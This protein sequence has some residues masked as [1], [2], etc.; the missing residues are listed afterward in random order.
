[1]SS[2]AFGPKATPAGLRSHRLVLA[3]AAVLSVPSMNEAPPVTR[4]MMLVTV[5]APEKVAESPVA[6]LKVPKLWKTLV[7]TLVPPEM[8]TAPVGALTDVPSPLPTICASAIPAKRANPRAKCLIGRQSSTA[9]PLEARQYSPMTNPCTCREA[10]PSDLPAVLA[11]YAQPELD[12][13]QVL[14]LGEAE[15]TLA[16]FARY[17]DYRLYV[18][19]QEGRVVGAYTLA[20]LDNFCHRGMPH[21]VVEDVAVDPALHRAGIGRDMMRHAIELCRTKGCYKLTLSSNLRRAGAHAFYDSLGFE[22]HG[23]SFRTDLE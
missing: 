15:K 23:Y 19:E 8:V 17:P 21:G 13:D 16:R 9:M 11:L 6:T 12:G 14:S 10:S 22:R 18:A 3:P 2:E 7:P 4:A 5:P 20:I 1:M